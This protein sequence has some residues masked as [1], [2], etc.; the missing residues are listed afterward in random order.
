ML[1]SY[2]LSSTIFDLFT[3]LTCLKHEVDLLYYISASIGL[4]ILIRNHNWAVTCEWNMRI[5]SDYVLFKNWPI[6]ICSRFFHCKLLMLKMSRKLIKIFKIL[7]TL[8]TKIHF[9]QT[10]HFHQD[11]KCLQEKSIM[12]I[13]TFSCVKSACYEAV[14]NFIDNVCV[15][16]WYILVSWWVNGWLYVFC[17]WYLCNLPVFITLKIYDRVY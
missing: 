15:L 14:D 7:T 8:R 12:K 4:I 1:T 5:N 13:S 10:I 3:L 2:L 6:I 11:F 16:Y 17:R 9:I